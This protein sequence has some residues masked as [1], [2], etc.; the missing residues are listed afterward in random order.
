[1]PLSKLLSPDELEAELRH[2]GAERYHNLHPFHHMLHSG[3]LS[4]DQVKA[5]A[6]NRYCYQAAIPI[7]DASIVARMEEPELRREWR[8]RIID[9]DGN[10]S[11]DGGI[12]R[13]LALTDGLGIDRDYVVSRAGA[14]PATRFAVGAYIHFVREKTLLEA[15]A[16]SLTELFS[17]NIISERVS[18]ML[19]NY[20]FITEDTLRY[21]DKRMT[22]APRDSDFALNYVR[23]HVLRLDQQDAVLEALY[24][25]CNVLWAQL[26]ALY[27]AYV[28]PGH[29][30]PGA[31][32]PAN[33]RA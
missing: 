16:S 4:R 9:H 31:Y 8:R 15:I 23:R 29:I 18:G 19:A 5:W 13:W 10:G 33:E 3:E 20:D 14:L 27:H 12:R 22:Q 6:L 11:D 1:M 25:K 28:E 24:F 32:D 2:I 30:P 21:F 26:D 17:P 7:K